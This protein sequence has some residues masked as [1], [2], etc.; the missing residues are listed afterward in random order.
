[1]IPVFLPLRRPLISRHFRYTLLQ[2]GQKRNAQSG[3][4]E[5]YL[6][7]ERLEGQT[8]MHRITITPRPSQVDDWRLVE[9]LEGEMVKERCGEDRFLEWKV[10]K[11]EERVVKEKFVRIV[12]SESAAA[13]KEFLDRSQRDGKDTKGLER[14]RK[15]SDLVWER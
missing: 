9:K 6:A 2:Y 7:L 10:T 1:M 13:V 5:L 4:Y 8:P 14:Y 3:V 15:L 12:D 11:A